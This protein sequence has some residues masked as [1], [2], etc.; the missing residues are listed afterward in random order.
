MEPDRGTKPVGTDRR[1][2]RAE[3][4]CAA[5]GS[6]ACLRLRRCSKIVSS[7]HRLAAALAVTGIRTVAVAAGFARD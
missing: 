2:P 7:A 5:R 3:H 6:S 1:L 4:G